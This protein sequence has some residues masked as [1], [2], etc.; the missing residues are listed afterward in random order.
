MLALD[1]AAD[2]RHLA[3]G[4]LEQARLLDPV[5]ELVLQDILVEQGAGSV[6]GS[7]E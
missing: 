6:T 3:E 7:S 5:D 4:A 2:H 1:Q